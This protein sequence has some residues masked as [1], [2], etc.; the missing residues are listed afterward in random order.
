MSVYQSLAR[1]YRPQSFD[2]IVGQTHITTALTNA[3]KLGREPC[4]VLFSGVRGVGKTTSARL[5]AK[6]LICEVRDQSHPCGRCRHCMDVER[7]GHADV[8]EI[9]GA[10][11]NGVEEVRQLQDLAGYQPVASRWRVFIIDEVH[12][13]SVSAFNALLKLLEEPPANVVFIFATTELQKVPQTILSR[14]QTYHLRKLSVQEIAH[15]LGEVLHAE[16]LV[17]HEVC[18]QRIA[19]LGAGSMRD[20]MTCL[21]Q[22]LALGGGEL[23]EDTLEQSG[24][25]FDEGKLIQFLEAM[26]HREYE[27]CL[28]LVQQY[29][30]RG[31][32]FEKLVGRLIESTR[33]AL[34][35]GSVQ[36]SKC[37]L[38]TLS[39]QELYLLQQWSAKT[40]RSDLMRLFR[41]L[42]QCGK[43]LSGA[44]VDRFIFENT[45]A[46]WCLD[47]VTLDITQLEQM[48][49]GKGQ[50]A[51]A[52]PSRSVDLP[53]QPVQP[54]QPAPTVATPQLEP[55][56]APQFP[57]TWEQLIQS[58]RSFKPLGARHWEVAQVSRY[59]AQEIH[60]YVPANNALMQ[61]DLQG[62]LTQFIQEKW[63]V[64]I[65]LVVQQVRGG[66]GA[67]IPLQ[68]SLLKEKQA[69]IAAQR[70]Q[71]MEVTHN[72]PVIK[73]IKKH[74]HLDPSQVVHRS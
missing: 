45:V 36:D 32:D 8:L 56:V 50:K 53:V 11:H 9:D 72:S 59:D 38:P 21:D 3:V 44:E 64:R 34:I 27:S 49:A 58:Y 52:K 66:E 55:Q 42:V 57:S 15:R 62:Q 46:E 33:H 23:S 69:G 16:G 74:F 4:A 47:T 25:W 30:D 24:L 63:D 41:C 48:L 18:L 39:E 19:V 68:E 5:Y 28:E 40:P 54:V 22:C 1:K 43:D 37:Y 17:G 13:L 14:C 20:A 29:V 61:T 6:A 67:S 60:V 10:S 26:S 35:C 70:A 71:D 51:L 2:Q 65:R 31:A 7:G 73:E 12:M